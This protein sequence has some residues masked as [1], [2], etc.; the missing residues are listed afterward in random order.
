[1]AHLCKVDGTLKRTKIY[2]FMS[3]VLSQPLAFRSSLRFPKFSFRFAVCDVLPVIL[4]S[5]EI[6]VDAV[7]VKHKVTWRNKYQTLTR[8]MVYA[9]FALASFLKGPQLTLISLNLIYVVVVNSVRALFPNCSQTGQKFPAG[10]RS[11]PR[12]IRREYFE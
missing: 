1:M 4:K 7:G 3:F 5:Q 8:V 10:H 11:V 9:G 2:F 12:P 6:H